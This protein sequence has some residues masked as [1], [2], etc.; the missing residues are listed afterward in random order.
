VL[1]TAPVLPKNCASPV[2]S[3]EHTTTW[4]RVNE[5]AHT[6]THKRASKYVVLGQRGSNSEH[7]ESCCSTRAKSR[8]EEKPDSFVFRQNQH[9]P[10]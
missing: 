4:A 5:Y 2:V 3:F 6:N 1:Q 8:K 10:Q 7:R 9:L